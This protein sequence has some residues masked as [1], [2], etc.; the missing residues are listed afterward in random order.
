MSTRSMTG[1]A[2]AMVCT[3]GCSSGGGNVSV[4]DGSVL[5]GSA[6]DGASGYDATA[7]DSGSSGG[8]AGDSGSSD[9]PASDSAPFTNPRPLCTQGR[10]PV[11]MPLP[12][13][14]TLEHDYSSILSAF[15][16]PIVAND[17]A[18]FV[19]SGTSIHR[20]TLADHSDTVVLDASSSS[21]T[22]PIDGIALDDTNLYFTESGIRT[23]GVG[24]IPLAGMATATTLFAASNLGPVAVSNG[25]VYFELNQPSGPPNPAIARVP[26]SGGAPTIL[27]N[28][29]GF[30]NSLLVVGGFVY[31][32]LSNGSNVLILRVPVTAQ[33][34][35]AD[36]G[37][38]ADSG[39]DAGN[40]N[41]PPGA[42][43][44][45]ATVGAPVAGPVSDG[46]NLFWGDVDQ[47]M[48][49]PLAGGTP[50]SIGSAPPNGFGS[51][52]IEFLAA[53]AGVAY[54]SYLPSCA[55]IVKSFVGGAPQAALVKSVYMSALAV[56][57][58]KAF[59]I[60][61]SGQLLSV[62]R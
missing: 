28:L 7:T 20:L 36:A 26:V 45:V 50:A 47:Q 62:A 10:F 55:D 16:T 49:M 42:E 4:P 15:T 18:V 13:G 48:T 61:G 32:T 51:S 8:P 30:I 43:L 53:A 38:A 37:A 58:T 29:P 56:N 40:P 25:Y 24:M 1:A 14:I 21:S 6:P 9:A 2:L 54:W 35:A 19:S 60:A 52:T 22:N 59:F 44:V 11:G 39:A 57:S 17:A 27:I 3:A 46:T 23:S 34:P 41:V 33:A 31:F 12:A 5:D